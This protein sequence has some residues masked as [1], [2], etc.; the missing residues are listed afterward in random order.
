MWALNTIG[1]HGKENEDMN[2][3]AISANCSSG[4]D[5]LSLQI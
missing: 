4:T 2:I 5:V 1:P 3:K